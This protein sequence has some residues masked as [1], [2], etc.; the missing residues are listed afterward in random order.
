MPTWIFRGFTNEGP[1]DG[2]LLTVLGQDDTGGIIW[3][4]SVLQRGGGHGLHLTADNRLIDT[5]AGDGCP[6]DVALITP[7]PQDV[8]RP[9]RRLL[10]R[11]DPRPGDVIQATDDLGAASRSCCSRLPGRPRRAAPVIG[12]GMSEDRRAVPRR[13]RAARVQPGLVGR[14]RPG[15]GMLRHRHDETQVLMVKAG[16]WAV[17]LNTGRTSRW[18]SW[19]R[20]TRCRC[21]P[22]GWRSITLLDTGVGGGD[23]PAP[24]SCWWSTAATGASGWSGHPRWWPRRGSAG[25]MLDRTATWRPVAVMVTAT[26]DD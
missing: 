6:T 17:T 26:E 14:G 7:M 12:Y 24:G 13:A 20:R 4:P 3:G 8:H 22:G 21:R 25:W 10:R 19:A 15:E 23:G 18:S 5:V 16:R 2:I 9:T 11:G 1:D